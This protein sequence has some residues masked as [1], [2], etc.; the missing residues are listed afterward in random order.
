MSLW[1][2]LRGG[3]EQQQPQQPQAQPPVAAA[4]PV[5]VTGD[6]HTRWYKNGID[7]S[8][9]SGPYAC[10]RLRNPRFNAV[11]TDSFKISRDDRLYAIGSCFARGIEKILK[12]NGFKVESAA[13]DFDQFTTVGGKVTA[14]GFTNK[15][16]TFSILNELRWALEPAAAFPEASLVDLDAQHCIDP[17]INPA[18]L[19]VDRAGTLERRR[20][21]QDVTRRIRDCRVVFITLGLVEVWYDTH[22]G[23][24]LNTTPTKEMLQLFPKR[25]EFQASNYVQNMENM[26]K[27]HA[28]LTA[29]GHPDLQIVITTSPVPLMA[30]FTGRDIVVA[31]TY[32]KS[33]LRAV[34][35]DFALAHTNVRYFPS[36]EMVMNSDRAAAWDNDLRHVQGPMVG[37]IMRVFMQNF[38][39]G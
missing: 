21:I 31:N 15:Y 32:S 5:P 7:T 22:A 16:T 6:E 17:H 28:L 36:Y 33:T 11:I 4:E 8:D 27:L 25:Y 19:V 9:P 26:E 10:Q 1:A 12:G 34:A 3:P 37:E 23:V 2:K 35:Q 30:T 18:L 38:V 29:H 24:H 39:S 13:S 20:I 14:L